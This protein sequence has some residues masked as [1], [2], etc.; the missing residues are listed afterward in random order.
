MSA[1]PPNTEKLIIKGAKNGDSAGVRALLEAD[2]SL[3]NAR[4]IDNSTPLHC[5][6]WKGH[7]E[8]AKVLLEFGADVNAKNSNDHWGDT[9]LHAA[10]HGNQKAVAEILVA[11]GANINAVNQDGRKPIDETEF[12]KATTAANFLKK[13]GASL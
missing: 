7:S 13:H 4:D 1:P 2:A 9:P 6:A 3:V 12:H 11:H 10:A 5:A 8:V